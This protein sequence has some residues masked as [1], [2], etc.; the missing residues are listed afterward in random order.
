MSYVE[1]NLRQVYGQG[2]SFFTNEKLITENRHKTELFFFSFHL[3]HMNVFTNI[4]EIMKMDSNVFSSLSTLSLS[5][6]YFNG[7]CYMIQNM[8]RVLKK[9]KNSNLKY[10]K[11]VGFLFKLFLSKRNLYSIYRIQVLSVNS[12]N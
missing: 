7:T 8:R 2:A 12:M 5:L 3:N 6:S 11:Q 4:E 1:S 9:E 10:N